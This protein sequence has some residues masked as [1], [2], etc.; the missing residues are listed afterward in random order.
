MV[1]WVLLLLSCVGFDGERWAVGE[2][3][4]NA[5]TRRNSPPSPR[6]TGV[7]A[8]RHQ[9]S[10]WTELRNRLIQRNITGSPRH[11]LAS[12]CIRIVVFISSGVE[13]G[14][15]LRHR[16]IISSIIHKPI[17]DLGP[18]RVVLS[19]PYMTSPGCNLQDA[20]YIYLLT[21]VFPYSTVTDLARLRG[22]STLTP[23]AT[24]I[25]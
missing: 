19:F 14:A 15:I 12:T 6:R 7:P 4:W 22:M 23:S 10:D 13:L 1:R 18:I 17:Q 21:Q 9:P 25:Q 11:T 24:A 8:S 16:A 20:F 5:G 3:S 2:V